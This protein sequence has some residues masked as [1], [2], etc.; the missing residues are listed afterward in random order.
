MGGYSLEGP[1]EMVA[2]QFLPL[3]VEALSCWLHQISIQ[4]TEKPG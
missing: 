1:E 3:A 4:E 2:G